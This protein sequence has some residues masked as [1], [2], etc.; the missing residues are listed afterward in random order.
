MSRHSFF[1]K[2]AMLLAIL[3]VGATTGCQ[4]QSGSDQNEEPSAK[5]RQVTVDVT[6]MT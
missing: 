1:T 6:G 4:K 2:A 5:T 3:A